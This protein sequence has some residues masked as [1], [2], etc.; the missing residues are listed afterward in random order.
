MRELARV[1]E[2]HARR[3]PLMAP[4]DGVKL[5]YQNEFSG[6]HLIAGPE[7]SLAR[8]RREWE[9]VPHDF[10]APVLEDIGGGLARVRLE[11]VDR[12]DYPLE[13]LNRDFIRSAARTRGSRAGFGEKLEVLRRLTAAGRFSFSLP[14]LNRYLEDY[15]AAGCPPVSHSPGYRE[16][17]RP[18][19]RVV[20]P[21][22][23]AGLLVREI[24]R[25]S[26]TRPQVLAA[27]DG[28]CAAGKSTL[29]A[30]LGERYGWPVVHM[31]HFF[32]RPEQQT[33]ERYAVPGENVD[34]ERFLE[35]VL[36]PLEERGRAVYRPYSCH[37]RTL[38]GP[39]EVGP[40]PV[41]LVEGSY[42]C[43]RSLW[44][45]YHLRV[46]LTVDQQE[47][48]SRLRARE[49]EAGVQVF[50]N[51]WIPLEERYFISGDVQN[52]CDLVLEL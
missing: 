28:R 36:R 41:I 15:L 23:A 34:H 19:Y 8:L 46:F 37:T 26:K 48:L 17:Y 44:D 5:I 39:V 4:Q 35:E 10:S 3:Y 50:Q 43:H 47:Q 2:E 40:A 25:L 27:I 1:L 11:A 52:R 29:A 21:A 30:R 6:G 13:E 9:S 18:A 33:P 22:A 38:A 24:K 14:E 7:E 42:A 51:R 45:H 49:G 20:R 32:L 12:E 16:A 31:D